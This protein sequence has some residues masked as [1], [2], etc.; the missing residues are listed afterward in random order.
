M[1]RYCLKI[2]A[3]NGRAVTWASADRRSELDAHLA[4]LQ[5]HA[6]TRTARHWIEDRAAAAEPRHPGADVTRDGP[7]YELHESIEHPAR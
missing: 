7:A 4:A 1:Q 2:I 3:G 6:S 5:Q